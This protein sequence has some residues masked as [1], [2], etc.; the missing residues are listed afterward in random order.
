MSAH[1]MVIMADELIEKLE[2]SSSNNTISLNAPVLSSVFLLFVYYVSL[3][4]FNLIHG[5]VRLYHYFGLYF[6]LKKLI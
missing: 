3:V 1:L 2:N 4:S 5:S 6:L